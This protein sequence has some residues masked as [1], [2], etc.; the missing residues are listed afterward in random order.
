M[1]MLHGYVFTRDMFLMI[2]IVYVYL[3]AC[4]CVNIFLFTC[5]YI[6]IYIHHVIGLNYNEQNPK[7]KRHS[8]GIISHHCPLMRALFLGQ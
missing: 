7:S 1:Y 2:F 3:Y 8:Q 4:V 5:V 6:Y